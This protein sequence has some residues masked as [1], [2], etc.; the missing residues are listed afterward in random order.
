MEKF[1]TD[2]KYDDI[3]YNLSVIRNNIAEYAVKSGRSAED[4]NFMAVTKTVAPEYI[5]CAIS[6]GISLIGENRVQE[7]LEKLP[8]LDMNG[9][10]AHLIGHLQTN[11]VRKIIGKVDLIQSV[12]TINLANEISRCAGN[13]GIVQDVL[14]E[15]NVGCEFSKFG[16]DPDEVCDRISELAEID[17]IRVRGLMCVAPI[18]ED[19]HEL[20]NIFNRMYNMFVDI[21]SKKMDNVSMDFLSMGMS[22]DYMDAIYCGSN[23]VRVGSAIFGPRIYT[24]K[25]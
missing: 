23:L 17:N 18:C 8:D 9:C 13:N 20:H 2:P 15:V 14:A 12:D 7:Y 19:K 5:N 16:F 11:K 10:S 25:H 1:S 4:I 22:G 3:R 21:G 24:D 6:D